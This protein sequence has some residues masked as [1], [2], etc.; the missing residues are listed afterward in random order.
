MEASY[1]S[2]LSDAEWAVLRKFVPQEK[3][4]GRPREIDFRTLLNAIFY[5]N[6][7]GIQWRA[8]PKDFCKWQS[9]YHYFRLWRID[10]TWQRMNDSLRRSERQAQG[11]HAEPSVGIVDS[12]SAKTT[13]KK[14][15]VDTTRERR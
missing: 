6:K 4:R 8:L 1:P 7:E 2:D 10:G 5:V 3:S 15:F 9:A 12:Q 14:E 11:R 13:Q